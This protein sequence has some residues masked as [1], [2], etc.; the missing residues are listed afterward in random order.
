MVFVGRSAPQ[1]RHEPI[2]SVKGALQ[3]AHII[4]SAVTLLIVDMLASTWELAVLA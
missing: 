3:I 4:S 2:D 1:P